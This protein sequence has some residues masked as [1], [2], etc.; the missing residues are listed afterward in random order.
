MTFPTRRD[1]LKVSALV[2]TEAFCLSSFADE[3]IELVVLHT[4]DHHGAILPINGQGGLA[5]KATVINRERAKYK[6]VL[7]VDS[8][9][10]NTGQAIS[11]QFNAK[12]DLIAYRLMQ[13]DVIT[14]GNHE[15][16]HSQEIFQEQ[17][18]FLTSSNAGESPIS[19]VCANVH[20]KSTGELVLPP[21]VVK[22]IEGLRVGIFGI[23]INQPSLLDG[24]SYINIDNE[25]ETAKKIVR[26]LRETER[27]DVVIALTHMGDVKLF[28]GH[29]TSVDLGNEVEGIDLIVDGHAHSYFTEPKYS[30][31]A[32]VVTANAYSRYVGKAIFKIQNGKALL[33]SWM[34]IPVTTDIEPDPVIA[35]ALE[36]YIQKA[37]ADLKTVIATASAPF[38]LG[39]KESR[40]GECAVCNLVCDSMYEYLA[41]KG[42]PVDFVFS[43]GGVFR[44]GI[45][46]GAVTKEDVKSCLP[47][48]NTLIIVEM[49]G[50]DVIDFFNYVASVYQT[51]GAFG[52]VSKQ[53]RYTI[54]YNNGVNGKISDLTINSEP[55]D[56]EKIYKIAVNSY[57]YN[58]GDGY[59]II[60]QRAVKT[61]NTNIFD[62]DSVIEVLKQTTQPIAP[63]L[64]G[65]IV[66]RGGLDQYKKFTEPKQTPSESS[67]N[68]TNP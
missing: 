31:N 49:K 27:A 26:T 32:P 6:Y 65:R 52:Q 39:E 35:K 15:F 61:I 63:V 21:Y 51:N 38:P 11:N 7:L 58:G 30:K 25:I 12:P 14:I 29:V 36:P 37:S 8:G 1:F 64:D 53:V 41:E 16:D 10:Y 43:N 33:D 17:S 40:V 20:Y 34:V 56:P 46:Q 24:K 68:T 59:D 42:M 2:L 9:D 45:P 22:Q 50:S 13:Y 62:Y 28:D 57:I 55:V 4:N 54:T 5:L 47:Y 67:P 18:R 66:V 23:L 44:A 3:P 60:K 48:S 19:L